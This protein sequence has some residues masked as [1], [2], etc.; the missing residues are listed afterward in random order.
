MSSRTILFEKPLIEARVLSR[1]NRYVTIAELP[2]G[3]VARCFTPVGG[4]IGGFTIDGLR[5]LLSGP[6]T[7]RTTK[8]TVEALKFTNQ[9][10]GINQ[11]ASNKFVEEF[12]KRGLLNEL[13]GEEPF[14]V[15]K[16]VT[17]GSS[18]IDFKLEGATQSSW[19][20]IKTPLIHFPIEAPSWIPLKTAYGN[21]PPSKRMPKQIDDMLTLRSAG[22]RALLLGVFFYRQETGSLKERYLANLDLDGLS[23]NGAAKGL[24]S[25][26]LTLSLTERGVTFED[27]TRIQ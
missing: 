3:Q 9:W 23:T 8:Y 10:V 18:R 1:P 5:C 6:Y 17:L 19:A 22:E 16:E 12:M 21:Y 27:V 20:E 13:H 4:R 15:R 24:E 26:D 25:W 14:E 2:T 7:D 11:N